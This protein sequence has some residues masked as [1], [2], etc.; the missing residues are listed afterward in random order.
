MTKMEM[1][2]ALVEILNSVE[3]FKVGIYTE[4]QCVIDMAEAMLEQEGWQRNSIDGHWQ[5][6][7]VC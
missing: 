4:A 5:K 2:A 1:I 3:L 6:D 7:T